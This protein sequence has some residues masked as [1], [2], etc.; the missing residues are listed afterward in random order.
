MAARSYSKPPKSKPGA[1]S[2]DVES[3]KAK[4]GIFTALG[5]CNYLEKRGIEGK[6]IHFM[7]ELLGNAEYDVNP[8]NENPDKENGKDE[9]MQHLH[10]QIEQVLTL[11]NKKYGV[12]IDEDLHLERERIKTSN[13]LIKECVGKYLNT[14]LQKSILKFDICDDGDDEKGKKKEE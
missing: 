14:T 9:E 1:A 2:G 8:K 7:K 5:F 13:G 11:Y 3:I 12:N 10:A 4:N 6:K